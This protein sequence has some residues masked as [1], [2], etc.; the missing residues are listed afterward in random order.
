MPQEKWKE[1]FIAYDNM[2]NLDR[3]KTAKEDL[4][5]PK[6]CHQLWQSVSKIIDSFHL[7]NHKKEECKVRFNPITLK[8]AHPNFNTQSCEQTFSW[9]SRFHRILSSIPKRHNHFFLHR[10]VKRRNKYNIYCYSSG[11]KPVLPNV[12]HYNQ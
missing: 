6:P 7:R 4:P 3:M 2:C 9:L 10:L 5:L 1:T 11:K 8:E 12:K